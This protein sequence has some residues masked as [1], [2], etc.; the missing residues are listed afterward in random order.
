[1]LTESG[2]QP[3]IVWGLLKTATRTRRAC[4]ARRSWLSLVVFGLLYLALTVLNFVLL[5]R[6][7]RFDP[8][9]VGGEGDEFAAPAVA[10]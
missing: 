10:Y 4:R 8:P 9:E 1:M 7:A 5:R 6:Y 2:R 3:W